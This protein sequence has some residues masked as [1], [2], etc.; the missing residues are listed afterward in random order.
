MKSVFFLEGFQHEH[1]KELILPKL[2]DYGGIIIS[3]DEIIISNDVII[4]LNDVK[5][6]VIIILNDVMNDEI[7]ILELHNLK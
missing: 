2:T 4:I 3:N 1:F 5:N 7:I 6:G